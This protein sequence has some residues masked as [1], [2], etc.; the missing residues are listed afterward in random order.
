MTTPSLPEQADEPSQ[1]RTKS[2]GLLI[3]AAV[4]ALVATMVI[5]HL[6]GVVG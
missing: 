4:I 2:P 1:P 5:L 3:A 6:T